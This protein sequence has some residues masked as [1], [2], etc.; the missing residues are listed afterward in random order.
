[1]KTALFS[2]AALALLVSVSL[3][4]NAPP[5]A[6][7]G[8]SRPGSAAGGAGG[9]DAE[10][11]PR[12][13][14][15]FP[16]G[17]VKEFVAAVAKAL[18]KPVNVIISR[19]S[20][21]TEIPALDVS[22]VTVRDLFR[23]LSNSS[24]REV[25][26]PVN[27][28]STGS[29][30]GILTNTAVQYKLVSFIFSTEET[31]PSPDAVWTFQATNPPVLP[32]AESVT[33]P[34]VVQYFPVADFLS[35]FTVEDITT[36]IQSGWTLQGPAAGAT[37]AIRFHEETKLLIIAGTEAQ[38]NL[39]PQVLDGLAKMLSFPRT[40]NLAITRKAGQIIVPKLEFREA[41]LREAVD[42]LRRKSIE[43]DPEHQGFNIVLQL[44]TA[45]PDQRRVTLA[46]SQVP[47]LEAL[48]YVASLSGLELQ[49]DDHAFVLRERPL[50]ET[51][52]A[53]I[54]APPGAFP[55]PGFPAPPIQSAAPE[56]RPLTPPP[57]LLPPAPASLSEV[58][59][60]PPLRPSVNPA[61]TSLSPPL[62]PRR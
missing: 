21:D 18:G 9:G 31:N 20:E 62:P 22:R 48:K 12:F 16:G 42:F 39:I 34:W 58:P 1:M 55:L 36:A 59:Q 40:E 51:A 23:A 3:A 6:L 24:R 61:P 32:T 33:P 13:D 7:P 26:V 46:L 57:A 52:P 38:M 25:A 27:I 4:Q 56:L 43:L 53:F 19:E 44:T 49:I 8:L 37:S 60:L 15:K 41:T 28:Q 2:A 5:A 17:K 54:P 30:R 45:E 10:D 11:A 29:P 35:H 14:L 50:R 47:A